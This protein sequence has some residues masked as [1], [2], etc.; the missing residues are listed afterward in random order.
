MQHRKSLASDE[1]L[2]PVALHVTAD[3]GAVEN[4]EGGEQRRGE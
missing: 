3:D 2:V 4:I 1:L